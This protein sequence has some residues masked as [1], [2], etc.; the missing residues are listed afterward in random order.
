MSKFEKTFCS[1]CGGKF[2]PGESGYSHCDQHWDVPTLHSRIE[3][4]LALTPETGEDWAEICR[5]EKLAVER[6]ATHR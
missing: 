3:E 4:L 5:L 1:H 2:G 6:E